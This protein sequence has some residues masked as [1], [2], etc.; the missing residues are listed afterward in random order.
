MNSPITLH[1]DRSSAWRGLFFERDAKQVTVD[2][3]LR[4]GFVIS[5]DDAPCIATLAANFIEAR[6]V[7]QK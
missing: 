3:A 5:P 7:A 2:D 4:E 1:L 6:D